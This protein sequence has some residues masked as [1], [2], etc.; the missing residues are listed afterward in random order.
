MKNAVLLLFS[1]ILAIVILDRPALGLP[2]F[3]L[4]QSS[5]GTASLPRRVDFAPRE[6]GPAPDP[7]PGL[8]PPRPGGTAFQARD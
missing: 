6:T 3:A 7:A 8:R 4:V 2:S 1:F 5:P